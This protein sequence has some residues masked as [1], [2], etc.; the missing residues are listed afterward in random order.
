MLAFVV[1]LGYHLTNCGSVFF[2]TTMKHSLYG[3]M[4]YGKPSKLMYNDLLWPLSLLF[5]TGG[6]NLIHYPKSLIFL[7]S[8]S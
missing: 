1:D 2:K 3:A 4:R 6:L 5:S 7:K 8:V